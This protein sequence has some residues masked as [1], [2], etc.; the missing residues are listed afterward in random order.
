MLK[1]CIASIA[2]SLALANIAF[3]DPNHSTDGIA[4]L[5]ANITA[6]LRWV[7]A[8][9]DRANAVLARD[10][11]GKVEPAQSDSH[12]DGGSEKGDGVHTP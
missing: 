10:F 6:E 11:A 2:L 5:P 1:A 7:R 4:E 3:A 8:E 12:P 9:R